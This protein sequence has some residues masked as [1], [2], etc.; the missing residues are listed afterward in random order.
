[1][2]KRIFILLAAAQENQ[3]VDELP[4][5]EQFFIELSM[6]GLNFTNLTDLNRTLTDY[7]NEDYAKHFDGHI[8]DEVWYLM[9]LKICL[10]FF[11]NSSGCDDGIFAIIFLSVWIFWKY[12]CYH[13]YW[14]GKRMATEKFFLLCLELRYGFNKYM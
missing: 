4:D 14:I 12:N 1:M 11:S 3:I 5:Y 7:V 6:D 8:E 2:W 10:H 9:N 13:Y